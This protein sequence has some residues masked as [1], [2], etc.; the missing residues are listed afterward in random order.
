MLSPDLKIGTTLASFQI[1]GKVPVANELLNIIVRG[2][3]S[4]FAHLTAN[5]EG[6]PSKPGPLYKSSLFNFAKPFFQ[7][8]VDYLSCLIVAMI[9]W[10][11]RHRRTNHQIYLS[12]YISKINVPQRDHKIPS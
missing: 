10:Y 2:K 4:D 9:G 3:A 6:I 11:H 5:T 1:T 12:P 7:R 8:A